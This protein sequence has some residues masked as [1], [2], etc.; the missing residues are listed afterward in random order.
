MR[1]LLVSVALLTF[2]VSLNAQAL[3]AADEVVA[4]VKANAFQSY[5]S[6]PD[7]I[8]TERISSTSEEKGRFIEHRTI[9]SLFAS[10]RVNDGAGRFSIQESRELRAIDGKL[11]EKNA[12]MPKAPYLVTGM[13]VSGA[14]M[15]FGVNGAYTYRAVGFEKAGDISA[16]K[17]EFDTKPGQTTITGNIGRISSGVVLVD[18]ESM[19]PVHIEFR[20][21]NSDGFFSEDFTLVTLDQK[22]YWLPRTVKA[23]MKDKDTTLTFVAEYSDCRKFQVSAQIKTV[24]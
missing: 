2:A 9:D 22:A 24:P 12:K 11:A 15:V 23:E 6:L 7:F 20:S 13:A 3:P 10:A 17:I 5:T 21:K 16:L 14:I 1:I 19:Q 8:C 18:M 4:K